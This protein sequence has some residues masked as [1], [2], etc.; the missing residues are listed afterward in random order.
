MV[1][2]PS[3]DHGPAAGHAVVLNAD[4]RRAFAARVV[5]GA[6][7]D[8]RVRSTHVASPR[9]DRRG[10]WGGHLV[11]APRHDR[12]VARVLV[13]RA[14]DEVVRTVGQLVALLVVADDHVAGAVGRAGVEPLPLT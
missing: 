10:V 11:E 7:D 3:D 1:V 2:L 12:A 13:V 5:V 4:D 9:A 8:D 14:E 6:A